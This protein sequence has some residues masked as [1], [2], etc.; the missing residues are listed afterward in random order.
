VSFQT[1][2]SYQDDNIDWYC[3]YGCALSANHEGEVG[4]D[5]GLMKNYLYLVASTMSL[6]SSLF[7]LVFF[8]LQRGSFGNQ[9][10]AKLVASLCTNDFFFSLRVLLVSASALL[11]ND[12]F[13]TPGT[14][15]CYFVAWFGEMFGAGSL[16]WNF[17]LVFNLFFMVAKPNKYAVSDANILF[18]CYSLFA[19]CTPL[20][21]TLIVYFAG[22]MGIA[23]DGTCWVTGDWYLTTFIPFL[24]YFAW[25]IFTLCFTARRLGA[26]SRWGDNARTRSVLELVVFTLAYSFI[27]FWPLVLFLHSGTGYS[28]AYL[29]LADALS[30]GSTGFVNSIVWIVIIIRS[31]SR[32]RATSKLTNQSTSDSLEQLTPSGHVALERENS[33]TSIVG[34]LSDASAAQRKGSQHFGCLFQS[35]PTAGEVAASGCCLCQ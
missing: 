17:V 14:F 6:L 15:G 20:C 4:V 22:K 26:V 31:R 3:F 24:M 23:A 1:G 27:G 8:A 16:C 2:Y 21:L 33:L 13:S 32:G 18:L 11:K 29:L 9:F 28:Y 30:S 10:H 35:P 7:V 19:W 34:L 12:F 25:A 5:L